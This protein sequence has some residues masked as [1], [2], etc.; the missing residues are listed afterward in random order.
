VCGTAARCA[1]NRRGNACWR[2]IDRPVRDA[3]RIVVW[4][5]EIAAVATASST[6]QS[7]PPMTSVDS[8][9]KIASSSS[10]FSDR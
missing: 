8:S 7:Q 3:G 5:E 6:I 2:A 1:R 10:A 9:A 4:V